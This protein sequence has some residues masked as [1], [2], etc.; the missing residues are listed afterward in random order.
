MTVSKMTARY[1]GD[2]QA[3][4]GQPV[5]PGD[6]INYGGRGAVTHADCGPP[7]AVASAPKR[8]GRCGGSRRYSSYDRCNHEDY[9][10]CGC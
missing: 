1:A 2:C 5:R 9:P 8:S 7:V 3:Q 6:E 10:C 4:C